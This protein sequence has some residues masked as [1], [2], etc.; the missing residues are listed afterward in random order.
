MVSLKL[1]LRPP[2]LG[3]WNPLL[4]PVSLK[5]PVPLASLCARWKQRLEPAAWRGLGLLCSLMSSQCSQQGLR[6]CLEILRLLP[7]VLGEATAARD[8][9][10]NHVLSQCRVHVDQPPHEGALPEVL[11]HMERWA[12][13]TFLMY[14][15]SPLATDIKIIPFPTP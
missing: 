7:H 4:T 14:D 13:V 3:E 1:C 15:V 10:E 8:V 9:T 11:P 12:S 6:W 2:F 5:H